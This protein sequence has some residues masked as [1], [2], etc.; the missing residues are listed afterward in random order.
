LLLFVKI[1]VQVIYCHPLTTQISYTTANSLIIR[2]GKI[3]TYNLVLKPLIEASSEGV[4][5]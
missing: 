4:A 1:I 2:Q 5:R 3:I